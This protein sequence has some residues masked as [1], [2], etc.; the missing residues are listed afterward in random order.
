MTDAATDIAAAELRAV[1]ARTR[2]TGSLQRLQAKLSPKVLARDAARSAA[3]AGH[4]AARSAVAAVR[5][6]PAPVA[7][8]VALTGLLLARHRIAALFG[9]RKSTPSAGAKTPARSRS[10]REESR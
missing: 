9:R 6:N 7:G 4:S 1:E 5:D 3:D 8:A 10:N 2:L